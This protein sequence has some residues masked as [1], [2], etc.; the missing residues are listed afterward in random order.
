MCFAYVHF[1]FT[2]SWYKGFTGSVDSQSP[3]G[4]FRG[5]RSQQSSSENDSGHGSICSNVSPPQHRRLT[6]PAGP[7]YCHVPGR[8]FLFFFHLKKNALFQSENP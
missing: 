5:F 1:L 8:T 7:V 2:S 3:V 4:S 6:A